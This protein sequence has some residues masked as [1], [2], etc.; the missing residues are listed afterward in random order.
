MPS[1]K[2]FS[3]PQGRR[4]PHF[5]DRWASYT[6]GYVWQIKEDNM[7][8]LYDSMGNEGAIAGTILSNLR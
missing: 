7:V 2:T 1:F 4:A 8:F 3:L 5:K 6:D